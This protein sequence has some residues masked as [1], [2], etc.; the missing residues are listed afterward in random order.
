ML[1]LVKSV[2]YDPWGKPYRIVMRKL[3]GPPTSER[4]EADVLE[5]TVGNAVTFSPASS[6][7][8]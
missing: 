5:I 6:T 7:H 4:L 2:D 3:R 8:G 1:G